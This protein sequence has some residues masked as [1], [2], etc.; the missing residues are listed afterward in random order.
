LNHHHPTVLNHPKHEQEEHGR[1]DGELDRCRASTVFSA[2]S[3]RILQCE[4]TLPA[5]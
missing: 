4:T 1:N 5:I 3:A 2:Q